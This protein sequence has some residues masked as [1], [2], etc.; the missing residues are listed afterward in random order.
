MSKIRS[1]DKEFM[2][3]LQQQLQ[4]YV[5]EPIPDEVLESIIQTLIF[6]IRQNSRRQEQF[7]NIDESCKW[8]KVSQSFFYNDKEL[9]FTN[10]EREF[11]AL[12]FDNVN[13]T[14]TYNTISI[15]LWGESADVVK[16]ERIKT[17]VKQIRK[18]LPKN[19]IKNIFGYGY[20]VEIL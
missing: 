10:K 12:V 2:K 1:Q 18:K 17:L 4:D 6:R 3:L 11:L 9:T 19:I 16:Q 20:K 8:N 13:N 5:I 15:S 14:V 7:I